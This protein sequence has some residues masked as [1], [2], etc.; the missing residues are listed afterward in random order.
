[1]EAKRG[2]LRSGGGGR[3]VVGGQSRVGPGD[4]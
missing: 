2:L 4:L 1:M 3:L